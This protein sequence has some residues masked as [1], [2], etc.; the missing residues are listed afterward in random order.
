MKC[1]LMVTLTAVL[2]CGAF[3]ALWA[4]ELEDLNK[5]V[6]ALEETQQATLQ[7][8]Q[9]AVI[10]FTAKRIHLG[11][12]STASFNSHFGK[13]T[14]KEYAFELVHMDL[15]ISAD[16]TEKLQFFSDI[17]FGF[18]NH[19][20]NSNAAWRRYGEQEINAELQMVWMKYH[21]QD[22]FVVQFGRM[23]APF[24]ILNIEHFE[25]LFLKRQKP[26]FLRHLEGGSNFILFDD[27]ANGLVFSGTFSAGEHTLGYYSY[28]GT[29]KSDTRQVGGGGRLFWSL[30]KELIRIGVSNQTAQRGGQ[31]YSALGGDLEIKWHRFRLIGE[32][33]RGIIQ[34]AA[35]Q[36]TFYAQP[37]YKFFDGK[38][39]VFG[40]V[41]YL[42]DT[43]GTRTVDHDQDE[44]TAAIADPIKKWE[45]TAGV[46]YLPWPFL[47]TRL[48]GV[49]H[50]YRGSTATLGGLN[51]DYYSAEFS[52]TVSF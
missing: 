29:V 51:R 14:S 8:E 12:F 35:G 5:R 3:S 49:L 43:L 15:L 1:K 34:G 44:T 26:Q 18:E 40:Q 6:E 31:T 37:S 27:H 2:L 33:V 23:I 47:R 45:Y 10:P 22:Y 17:H 25:P 9:Q 30:P 4:G 46:N 20:E 48:E 52:A 39:V 42:D 21:F 50:D 36:T 32:F 11:G 38:F 41:D 16:V 28:V 13:D 19:F 24:G 7:A